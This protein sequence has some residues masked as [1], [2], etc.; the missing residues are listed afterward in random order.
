MQGLFHLGRWL[1]GPWSPGFSVEDLGFRVEDL[2]FR[3][4]GLV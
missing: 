2:G 3:V 1:A 4:S